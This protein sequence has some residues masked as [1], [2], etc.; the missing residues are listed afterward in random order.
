VLSPRVAFDTFA[1]KIDPRSPSTFTGDSS[2]GW[3]RARRT[4]R[5]L[6]ASFF[7][8]AGCGPAQGKGRQDD[9]APDGLRHRPSQSSSPDATTL[10]AS[11]P[12]GA[13]CA[14]GATGFLARYGLT[15]SVADDPEPRV[16]AR[17]TATGPGGGAAPGGASVAPQPVFPPVEPTP[18]AS[19][20]SREPSHPSAPATRTR[21]VLLPHVPSQP[22]MPNP[23]PP[24][25]A[26][27]TGMNEDGFPRRYLT[28]R[29]VC[30]RQPKTG[31]GPLSVIEL[32]LFVM[33]RAGCVCGAGRIWRGRTSVF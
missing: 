30:Q 26:M 21:V 3:S 28:H 11:V 23:K 17:S 20:T 18:A 6:H 1:G 4:Y 5:T 7:C 24:Y 33:R 27:T 22:T 8:V 9:Q 12:F 25:T 16:R 19:A 31:S 14:R 29:I 13:A 15:G 10:A 2:R 32:A